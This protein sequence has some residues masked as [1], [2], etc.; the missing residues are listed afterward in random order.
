MIRALALRAVAA[1]SIAVSAFTLVQTDVDR[2]LDARG[3]QRFT[4]SPEWA[5]DSARGQQA[6]DVL[7]QQTLAGMRGGAA[8]ASDKRVCVRFSSGANAFSG[9]SIIL[10]NAFVVLPVMRLAPH[11]VVSDEQVARA[12]ALGVG[13]LLGEL[14]L[15]DDALRFIVA[16]EAAHVYHEHPLA[17]LLVTSAVIV[18]SVEMLLAVRASHRS[19]WLG[20]PLALVVGTELAWR[21]YCEFAADA[22]ASALRGGGVETLVQLQRLEAVFRLSQRNQADRSLAAQLGEAMA[23]LLH[24]PMAWRIRLLRLREGDERTEPRPSGKVT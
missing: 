18:G 10:G 17:G 21:W 14:G 16:H 12:R 7:V 1:T 19:W 15:S 5:S 24:P 3:A 8:H 2:V 6:M 11:L 20:L 13:D 4:G 9:G 23:S 22:A